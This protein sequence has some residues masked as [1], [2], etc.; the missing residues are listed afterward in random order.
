M[1]GVTNPNDNCM[2]DKS[3]SHAT[4]AA[5]HLNVAFNSVVLGVN[6]NASAQKVETNSSAVHM[7]IEK[8]RLNRTGGVLELLNV[9]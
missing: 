7:D 1:V 4:N 5:N 2:A 8:E 3:L 6:D 9:L